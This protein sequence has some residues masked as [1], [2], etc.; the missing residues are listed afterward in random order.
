MRTLATEQTNVKQAA[1]LL[2]CPPCSQLQ[3]PAPD[4]TL[5]LD[6]PGCVSPSLLLLPS[7]VQFWWPLASKVASSLHTAACL[8]FGTP[9]LFATLASHRHSSLHSIQKTH[10]LSWDLRVP[11][12]L[13]LS[14]DAQVAGAEP[15]CHG[16]ARDGACSGAGPPGWLLGRVPS[17]LLPASLG[18]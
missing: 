7:P 11:L 14:L 13:Q 5:C 1:S 18:A 4:S 3:K 8:A 9:R 2:S 6:C 15:G 17:Q 16:R 12:T 10:L